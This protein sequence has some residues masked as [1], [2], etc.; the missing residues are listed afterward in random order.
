MT[1]DKLPYNDCNFI[2]RLKIY[3][4]KSGEFSFDKM[5]FGWMTGCQA[6]ENCGDRDFQIA[7]RMS[8]K[9]NTKKRQ[10][11]YN[12]LSMFIF[13]NLINVF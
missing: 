11:I 7:T 12:I 9:R 1:S 8:S 4:S 6:S 2:E 13:V 10:Y 3:F 5:F